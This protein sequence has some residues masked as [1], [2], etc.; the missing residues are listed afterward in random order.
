M[1]VT[2]LTHK[3]LL[4]YIVSEV[5]NPRAAEL[6]SSGLGSLME[7]SNESSPTTAASGGLVGTGGSTSKMAPSQLSANTYI[8][9]WLPAEGFGSS[10]AP[11]CPHNIRDS[12]AGENKLEAT[13]LL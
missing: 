13:V 8:P 6:G 3:H 5:K 11:G 4:S 1:L 2:S 12:Q 10:A 9:C 7:V